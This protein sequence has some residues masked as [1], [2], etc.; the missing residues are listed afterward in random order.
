MRYKDEDKSKV[1][2]NEKEIN[3]A[4]FVY[5]GCFISLW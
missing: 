1:L 5:D 3:D 2:D 4:I